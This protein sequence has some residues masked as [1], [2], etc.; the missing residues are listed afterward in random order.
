MV[1]TVSL[2]KQKLV[3]AKPQC[4]NTMRI[5]LWMIAAKLY[6]TFKCQG[7]ALRHFLKCVTN[8]I[9][10]MFSF[11]HIIFSKKNDTS[12]RILKIRPSV[13]QNY[14]IP[15][16]FDQIPTQANLLPVKSHSE[17]FYLQANKDSITWSFNWNFFYINYNTAL[18]DYQLQSVN[19][20]Y[21][22][23]TSTYSP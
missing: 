14:S 10:Q 9:R 18:Q 19:N 6:P 17:S 12:W 15:Y 1:S 23:N 22:R 13:Y 20:G 4:T 3:Y 16:R 21:A 8:S 5:H 2:R 7:E 11:N